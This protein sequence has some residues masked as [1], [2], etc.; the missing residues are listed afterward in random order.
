M[1]QR[2]FLILALFG[3]T[4]SLLLGQVTDEGSSFGGSKSLTGEPDVSHRYFVVFHQPPGD[5]ERSMVQSYGAQIIWA[6]KVIPA[7]AIYAPNSSVVD[8]IRSD[9]RVRYVDQDKVAYALGSEGDPEISDPTND[10]ILPGTPAHDITKIWIQQVDDERIQ[11]FIKVQ[12]LAGVNPATGD[13]LP[14]NSRWKVNFSLQ[15]AGR[16]LPDQY[17]VEMRRAE[18]GAP[19]FHWGFLS[20]TSSVT[21]GNADAGEILVGSSVIKITNSL[22]KFTGA[23]NQNGVP[24]NGDVLSAPFG[25]VQVLG[26]TGATGG[27][28]LQVERAPNS[29]GGR[30]FTVKALI[31]NPKALDF[32]SV[33]VGVSKSLT[34]T[35]TN[36][37]PTTLTISSV[38]SNNPAFTV[39]PSSATVPP[40]T[41]QTFTITFSPTVSG[42]ESGTILFYNSETSW[43]GTVSVRGSAF[44]LSDGETTPWGVDAVRAPQVWTRTT[45]KAVRVAVLDTGIDSLH[46]ELDG[47]YRGGYNFVARNGNPWDGHSHGT[48]VS[49]TIAAEL[50]GS[51]LMGVAHEVELYALKVLSDAGSGSF[52]DVYAAIDWCLQNRIHIASMSLGG[53]VY[54]ATGE[55]VFRNAFEAGLLSVAAA[56]NG[57]NGIGTPQVNYPAAY[58]GVVAV[59]AIGQDL[60]RAAFSDFG[61]NIE[62]VAPGVDVRSTVPRGSGREGTVRF[63]NQTLVANPLE[64][65]GLTTGAGR[66]GTSVFCGRGLSPADFPIEVNGNIAL[67]ERGDISFAE[68]VRNAQDAGAIGVI[69]YNNAAGNFSGT[70]GTPRDDVRNREWVP[71]VSLSQADGQTLASAGRPAI[72]LFNLVSDFA[73]F[74]GTS[75]ATPHVSALAALIKAAN[76]SLTNRQIRSVLQETATDLGA[77]SYDL[78][79]GYGL[80]NAERAVAR[81]T[82]P[83]F[84]KSGLVS[85]LGDRVTWNG[86]IAAGAD[87]S[88][89]TCTYEGPANSCD[90]FIL[91]VNAP[92]QGPRE[93]VRVRIENFGM[94]DLDLVVRNQ[95]G[96]TVAT[97]GAFPG[98]GEVASFP[99][100]P[101]VYEI[102]IVGFSAAAANYDGVA[103]VIQGPGIRQPT[104]VQ[105][106]IQFAPTVTPQ[107]P[108]LPRGGEPS[109][110]VDRDGFVYAGGIRG[111]TSGG[112]D[113]WRWDS[114]NDPCLRKPTYLGQ[115]IEIPETQLGGLGGGDLEIAVSQP[116]NPND[117]PVITV[118]SLLLANVPVAISFDRGKTW[119]RHEVG[120]LLIGGSTATDRHWLTAYGNNTLYLS[121]RSLVSPT[122]SDLYVSTSIDHGRTWSPRSIVRLG[123]SS[124]P[125]YLDVDRRPIGSAPGAG[126]I[127]YSHQNSSAMFVSVAKPSPI[128]G[129]SPTGGPLTFQT[130]VVD[131]ITGHGHLFDVLRVGRDG[132]LYAVWSDDFNIYLATSTD[133]ARTWS[134]PV[135]VNDPNTVDVKGR[136]VR[137][138][139]FPWVVPGDQG[140]VGIVWFGSNGANN[141]DNEGDWSVYYAFT[142][143]ALDPSPTFQQVRASDHFI[144]AFNVS[145]LGLGSGGASNRNLLDFFQVDMDPQGAA[146]VAFADDHNDFDGQVY[147][148]RQVGGPSLLASVGTVAATSCPP[149]AFDHN[150]DR[151]ATD[152]EVI[153]FAH[154]AQV[155]RR[156]TIQVDAPFD[157]TSI[158]YKDA[159]SET[160]ARLLSIT[161]GVSDM[162]NPPPEGFHWIAYF[163]ANAPDNLFDRG[164]SFYVDASTDPRDGASALSPLFFYG[165]AARRADGPIINTRVGQADGGFFDPEKNTVTILI[166]LDKVNAIAEPDVQIGSRLIGLRGITIAGGGVDVTAQAVGRI[167]G[168]DVERDY[169]RGGIEFIVGSQQPTVTL[170]CDDPSITRSGGWHQ[171]EDGRASSGHYCRNVGA[172]NGSAY[173]SFSFTGSSVEVIYATGPRGGNAEVFIDGV[174]QG[175]LSFFRP[176][177]DPERP[178]NS[179]KKDLTFGVSAR[180]TTTAGTHTFRLNV[181]NDESKSSNPP[182]NMVYLEKFVLGGAPKGTSSSTESSTA[183][184]A[185]IDPAS[186]VSQ[187]VTATASTTLL[188]GVLEFDNADLDLIVLDPLGAVAGQSRSTQSPEVVQFVPTQTGPYLFQVF[189]NSTSPASYT[190]YQVQTHGPAPSPGAEIREAPKQLMPEKFT[191][192]Q[193]FPNPF[194]P[195]TRISYGLPTPGLVSLKV[196]DMLGREVKTLERGQKPAGF[197]SISFDGRMLPSGVY[198]YRIDFT[199][200]RGETKTQIRSMLLLK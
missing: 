112:V 173:L 76:Y 191:L 101:G 32:A 184:S 176:A 24:G 177:S 146:V 179:G 79:Y 6:Y 105:G 54:D 44:S 12:S 155:L 25:Q 95:Q 171:V 165:T 43:P 111:L 186:L 156:T 49:G 187:V 67:I 83:S 137:T 132:T 56:G 57:V 135:Q 169:T 46:W 62:V 145:E 73:R 88:P 159:F 109:I 26:G 85:A 91:T 3:L 47:R 102:I 124:T 80:V 198:Y 162:T 31:A 143:N 188:T 139:I 70:L 147:V 131:N 114:R 13:G 14:P 125:G 48:H 42:S 98:Q 151:V 100:N 86:F 160:G 133:Q 170:A 63:G 10:Q 116:D 141:G 33:L 118:A 11:F 120:D 61:P 140:R 154:D 144:H 157:I 153:D 16:A 84:T 37:N 20:G 161:I 193:N 89:S 39:T 142:A 189:S 81:V 138:N 190:L 78:E 183:L 182:R 168:A 23:P 41:S 107:A 199:N 87:Q 69:I 15:Q 104:Y 196:F 35:V 2:W 97:S 8:A 50:N 28:L 59:G 1:K 22:S 150:P 92:L 55:L 29:G 82:D 30:S 172:K 45:G 90:R 194:N 164:Q 148:T 117:T 200:E 122:L 21:G 115:P 130:F 53:R 174:S 58:Q 195:E 66:T 72:S 180:Y 152:P 166:G 128:P 121:V 127:Y 51:G 158:D 108:E 96:Q 5:A 7:F 119:E 77:P 134:S 94:N 64:F 38:Q 110:R 185:T 192:D 197:H 19:T 113:L 129:V 75:M 181:L 68:K 60:Q 17:F 103:E 4:P 93:F 136:R 34:T 74:Q 175:T 167:T 149:I 106:G 9:S 52:A 36:T 71:A 65:A 163:T 40:G 27:V 99:A 18:T 123:S 178:D 126:N